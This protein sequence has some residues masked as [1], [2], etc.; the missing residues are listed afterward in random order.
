MTMNA[1][2]DVIEKLHDI[3]HKRDTGLSALMELQALADKTRP[4]LGEIDD[5]EVEMERLQARVE[6]YERRIP[7]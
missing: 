6:G 7:A 5:T 2:R 4:A 1:A 3:L